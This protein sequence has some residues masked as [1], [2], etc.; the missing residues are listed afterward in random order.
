MK[1][2]ATMRP[3]ASRTVLPERVCSEIADILPSRMPMWRMASSLEH[4]PAGTRTEL[5]DALLKKVKAGDFKASELWCIA[6]LGARELFY[7]P[8]NQV[9][10]SAVAGRWAEALAPLEGTSET[11]ARLARRTGNVTIDLPTATVDLLRAQLR[12][13]PEGEKFLPIL[14]GEG[15]KDLDAMGRVFGEELPAGLVLSGSEKLVSLTAM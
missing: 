5:G 10:S 1:P 12:R 8:L 4:L 2:G 13:K 3:V 9:L 14:E 15:G 6:R 7:G 11:V